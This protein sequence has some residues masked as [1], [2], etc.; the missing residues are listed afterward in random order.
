MKKRAAGILLHP[1]SL[2][3]RH[4]A[5][6]LGAAARQWVDRLSAAGTAYWQILPLGPTGFGNSPYQ[7]YSAFAG[8]PLLI[9]PDLLA[10]RGLLTP[11]ETAPSAPETG[12]VDYDAVTARRTAQLKQAFSRF[13]PSD[14][15][16]RFRCEHDGWL[17][18]YAL[19]MALTEHF[20]GDAWSDWPENVRLRDPE[21]MKRYRLRLQKSVDFHCFVQFCFFS[22]WE[23]LKAYA[24]G[25]GV[26]IIGDLPIYVAMNSADVWAQP[27]YFQL[28]GALRP[29][30]VAGVPP[31]YFSAT[32][33]RWGNPL[34]DWDALEKE[35]FSWW[36]QRL[37]A[38]LALFDMVRID[39]FRGFE[40]YWSV[41]AEEETA[42][43]GRWV[44][45]PDAKLF[46]AFRAAFG[47]EL[48]IIAEDL[49]IIT[50]EVEKLRD[51][52]G[53]PGMKILQ[54]AFG[55]DASNPYLPHNH[56]P[57]CIVYTGTHD[58]DTTN[59]WFYAEAPEE[60]E[61]THAMQYLACPWDAFHKSLNRAALASPAAL[62]VL[63]LQDLLGLGS[64]ARMNTPGTALGNWEWRAT[65][66][67]LDE[68]PWDE[69]GF[70]LRLYGRTTG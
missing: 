39:H 43:N 62:A 36:V 66:R 59:G 24:N 17:N 32:G 30:A 33:Q 26:E 47:G 35:H 40:A 61:R 28:D 8:N 31:D 60:A 65:Q 9:D 53:L 45:G 52:Y 27:H 54:F 57:N 12:K 69:L 22:Q 63:P 19:F 4:G 23:A 25:K 42:I 67:Q 64:D 6:T 5:G 29:V 7:C 10:E 3:G 13:R 50:P 11:E 55:G 21:T 20:N 18:D 15:Y 51:D 70:Q 56:I 68:A 58:N 41:P 16:E 14:A 48:P 2:P 38:S 49:G 34:F 46:D 37:K 1:T 44:K